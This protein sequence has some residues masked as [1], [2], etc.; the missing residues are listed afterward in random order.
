MRTPVSVEEVLASDRT[1][2]ATSIQGFRNGV[3]ESAYSEPIRPPGA[4][5]V[6]TLRPGLPTIPVAIWCCVLLLLYTPAHQRNADS[7]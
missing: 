5:C 7:V 4:G 6:L 3:T 2:E 1:G